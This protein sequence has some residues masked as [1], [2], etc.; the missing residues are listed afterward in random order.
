MPNFPGIF[1]K[2]I[3]LSPQ[4]G[5]RHAACRSVR[6]FSDLPMSFHS[7]LSPTKRDVN[8]P[9]NKWHEHDLV[10]VGFVRR[11]AD[12]HV[13]RPRDSCGR[14]YLPSTID[15]TMVPNPAIFSL[16]RPRDA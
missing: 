2:C 9:D 15:I 4:S 1:G 8:I 14:F 3:K 13:S 5:E 10:V 7:A 6:R 12:N 16:H 11:L